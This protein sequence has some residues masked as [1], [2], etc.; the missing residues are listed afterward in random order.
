M[1]EVGVIPVDWEVVEQKDVVKYINGRAF[2]IYEWEDIGVPVVRLQ[3]LTQHGGDFYYTNLSLPDKQYMDKGDL[4]Y[5][6][7]ASFGP[8]IWWGS[9][10]VFHY[11]IWKIECKPEADKYSRFLLSK[12]A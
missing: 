7:S 4:I 5:M 2:S 12:T 1:T 10:A 3:N 11:H 6:W 9:K 8:Y